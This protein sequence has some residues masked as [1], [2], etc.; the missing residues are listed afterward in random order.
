MP[1]VHTLLIAAAAF[2]L[3]PAL[4]ATEPKAREGTQVLLSPSDIENLKVWIENAKHDLELL[5]DDTRRGTLEERRVRIVRDFEAIV[6]RS[7]R[8]ENEILM[9]YTLNRALEVDELVGAHPAPSELQSLVAFLDSTVTLSKSFYTD[10]IRYLEAI[11]RGASPELQT[12]MPVFAYQYAEMILR[13]SRTFLRPELEYSI[14]FNA[15][16]W[17]AN[18]LNSERNLMRIQFAESI[19]RIARI[20]SKY[21][22]K[23]KATDLSL[24]RSIRDFKYEY[25]ERV[26]KHIL[27]LN[28]EIRD[29]LERAERKRAEDER[30]AKL[31]AEERAR[32]ERLSREE[33]ELEESLMRDIARLGPNVIRVVWAQFGLETKNTTRVLAKSCNRI[34]DSCSFSVN[35]HELGDPLRGHS[36][37]FVARWTCGTDPQVYQLSAGTN[38]QSNAHGSTVHLRC[39]GPEKVPSPSDPQYIK[40]SLASFG[41]LT[42]NATD[43]V[44]ATCEGYKNCDYLITS[45]A[46]GD[47]MRGISKRFLVE[48]SCG[49]DPKLKQRIVGTNHAN[50]ADGNKITISCE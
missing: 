10:D 46:L 34:V 8:K 42:G 2:A 7:S 3:S 44:R 49:N 27:S 20:Q 4:S 48:W 28:T 30:L 17:L 37:R 5:Q 39:P 33:R 6:G 15:L 47:P 1:A 21:P 29:S 50:N 19:M 25:R 9:R 40:I 23:P 13:F 24:L 14:T 31:S 41:D 45:Q 26:L 32:I 36:K 43:H 18:D 16:G 38:Y 12:P 35:G 11:G 22:E